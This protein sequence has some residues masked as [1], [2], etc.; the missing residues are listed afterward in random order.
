MSASPCFGNRQENPIG[1]PESEG[2]TSRLDKLGLVVRFGDSQSGTAL[3]WTWR[4]T[5]PVS[6]RAPVSWLNFNGLFNRN[7]NAASPS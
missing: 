3:L 4:R 1:A 6:V 5:H 2:G 7:V